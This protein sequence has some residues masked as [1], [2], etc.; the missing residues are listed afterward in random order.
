MA[1]VKSD[2]M[3][4]YEKGIR[5]VISKR[6]K[7]RNDEVMHIEWSKILTGSGCSFC[8]NNSSIL[9]CEESII[10]GHPAFIIFANCFILIEEDTLCI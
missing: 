7:V 8:S 3:L 9:Q 1:V 10:A 2:A 6:P 5:D 4:Q